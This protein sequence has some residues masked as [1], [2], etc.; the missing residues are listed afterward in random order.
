MSSCARRRWWKTFVQN[1]I[2]LL[3]RAH[4][5]AVCNRVVHAPGGIGHIGHGRYNRS[6]KAGK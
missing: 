6:F 4:G 3:V 1:S 5:P 2:T